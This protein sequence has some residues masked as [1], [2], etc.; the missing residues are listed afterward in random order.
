M[1]H[2]KKGELVNRQFLFNR[3]I[4]DQLLANG[5]MRFDRKVNNKSLKV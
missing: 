2:I 1:I 3:R 4:Y 5:K